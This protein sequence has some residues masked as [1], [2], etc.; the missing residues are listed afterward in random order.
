MNATA[1]IHR[2]APPWEAGGDA[3]PTLALIGHALTPTNRSLLSAFERLGL[4]AALVAP[5]AIARVAPQVGLAR[6]DVRPSLDG[7]EPGLFALR[8]AHLDGL[9]LLNPPAALVACHDKLATALR[10]AAAGIP[11]PRTTLVDGDSPLP[12]LQPP[13]VVKPRFGSWGRDVALCH[14][15]GELSRQ[16]RAFSKRPW[17]RIHGAVVQEYID[18]GGRDLRLVVA[19]GSVVGA[20]QRHAAPGEWRTNVCLG[21]TRSPANPPPEAVAVAVAAARAVGA[22]LAGVDLIP[23]GD[24]YI[25]LEINGAVDFTDDYSLPGSNVFELAAARLAEAAELAPQRHLW[26]EAS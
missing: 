21:A 2:L 4:A 18:G 14:G 12:E 25:V 3:N 10:L 16:L 23:T 19:G 8:H 6:L 17:F 5:D 22:D 15:R 11:H 7:I 1:Q 24:G 13:L 20:A 26:S 9:P